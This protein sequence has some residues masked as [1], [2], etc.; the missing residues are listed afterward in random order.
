VAFGAGVS[1]S[2]TLPRVFGA[3]LGCK[4]EL[5]DGIN[6]AEAT[7]TD[8][9]ASLVVVGAST[10]VDGSTEDDVVVSAT[11]PADVAVEEGV[12]VTL[13]T[14]VDVVE[15]EDVDDEL[16]LFS[17]MLEVEL[18]GA[19]T[20]FTVVIRALDV[21][22]TLIVEAAMKFGDVDVMIVLVDVPEDF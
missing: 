18:T 11:G 5:A 7:L 16:K 15:V 8:V 9:L 17:M 19:G 20:A 12:A 21:D 4:K 2:Y 10:E 13:G 1:T 22:E 6:A 14:A 3:E